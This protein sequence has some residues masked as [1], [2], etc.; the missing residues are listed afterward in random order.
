MSDYLAMP[1][2]LPDGWPDS[3]SGNTVIDC[4]EHGRFCLEIGTDGHPSRV[5]IENYKE[6]LRRWPQL[7]PQVDA[8]VSEMLESYNR[9]YMLRSP[10][11]SLYMRL[12]A[13]PITEG[14]E[15]GVGVKFTYGK[16]T[17]HVAFFG[18]EATGEGCQPYF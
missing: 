17:W 15:W 10:G 2:Q 3:W 12:P 5:H 11:A 18:W 13:E 8:V 16:G 1:D 9:D 14:V 7:W 4:G 6:I